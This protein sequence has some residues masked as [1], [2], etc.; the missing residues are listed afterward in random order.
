M[1]WPICSHSTAPAP[2]EKPMNAIRKLCGV[3]RHKKTAALKSAP[4]PL[5]ISIKNAYS[6]LAPYDSCRAGRTCKVET[7]VH[8]RLAELVG[9]KVAPSSPNPPRTDAA[10]S[11]EPIR[12]AR[13]KR[14]PKIKNT[15]AP[16]TAP[17]YLEQEPR[18]KDCGIP[19]PGLRIKPVH[20]GDQLREELRWSST[21]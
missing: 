8:I 14:T 5:P 20:I 4:R 12:F 13:S 21:P 15:P 2:V 19:K 16:K 11:T 9:E 7:P 17:P 18:P 3:S 1:G 10:T 6:A